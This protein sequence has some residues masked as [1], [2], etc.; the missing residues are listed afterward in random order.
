MK[1]F[2]QYK[3]RLF[4]MNITSLIFFIP[5]YFLYF[6]YFKVFEFQNFTFSLTVLYYFLHE[7]VHGIGF[8]VFGK[9]KKE[10][11]IYG[12]EL[13]KGI[14]YTM[15]IHKVS[16]YALIQTLIFPFIVLGILTFIIAVC[17]NIPLLGF[18]SILNMAGSTGDL[19]MVLSI[20][21]MPND[22]EYMDLEDSTGFL[23]LSNQ[24]LKKRYLGM[25]L[26]N[27]GFEKDIIIKN[28]KKIKITK[29][30]YILLFLVFL[31]LFL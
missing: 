17:F 9:V 22:I 18:L 10:N 3:I 13:E 27:Q 23:L 24:I 2:Y 31:L 16:K 11:I 7:V 19:L 21:K 1:K 4:I 5:M 30:S 12:I 25:Y 6:Y 28:H 14:F 15:C 8:Y 26:I 20:I 29:F